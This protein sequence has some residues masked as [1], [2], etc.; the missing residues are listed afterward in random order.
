[1][2]A[3]DVRQAVNAI[4]G[5]IAS[6][7]P[8]IAVDG[9]L[10]AECID[11]GIEVMVGARV[12]ADFGPVV[13][14]GAGGVFAEVLD[15]IVMRAAPISIGEARMMIAQSKVAPLLE[16]VRGKPRMDID[17]VANVLVKLS[18]LATALEDD[19]VELEI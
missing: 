4:Q 10:V 16:G 19:L 11:S 9:Y 7:D 1:K 3:D 12:D 5:R 6:L 14:F 13:T 8:G 18:D 2:S 15:D 17:A